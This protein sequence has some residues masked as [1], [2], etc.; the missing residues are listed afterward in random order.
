MIILQDKKNL[1]FF[2]LATIGRDMCGQLFS[3]AVLNYILFT[4]QLSVS[5]FSVVSF[6]IVAARL[7]DAFNDPFMGTLI[8]HTKTKIGKFKPWIIAGV[9]STSVV[10]YFAFSNRFIGW[11]FVKFFALIYFLFSI[12]FTMNDVSYWG[13]I[14]SL[15]SAPEMRDKFTSRTVFTSGMGAA[16]VTVFV[17]ILTAGEH[18][19]GGNAVTAYR[20]LAIIACVASPV[21]MMLLCFVKEN[22]GASSVSKNSISVS[23]IFR[24]VFRNDQLKWASVVFFVSQLGTV[25]IVNGL[26]TTYVYFEF[27]YNGILATL[28]V[29]VGMSSTVVMMLIYP[30]LAKKHSRKKL[31]ASSMYFMIFGYLWMLLSGIFLPYSSMIKYIFVVIGLAIANVGSYCVNLICM[32]CISNSIEYNE[33]KF[34]VREDG[35]ITSVRPFLTKLSNSFVML[36]TSVIYMLIGVTKITNLIS[37]VENRALSGAIDAAEKTDLIQTALSNVKNSQTFWLLFSMSVI[38][39][40]MGFACCMIFK[41][42]YTLDEDEYVR[43]VEELNRR[44]IE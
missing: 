16:F 27:G 12:C 19:I 35:V 14:P 17:P 1:I 44:K 30:A 2:P 42:K 5:Q 6:I 25:P 31:V 41:K 10:V 3:M 4:K 43:I 32:I 36:L 24:T 34:G 37:D 21:T 40:S 13:M 8:D 33:Y 11:G 18:V 28:F 26:G 15:S 23:G 9:L 29:V 38:A 20:V 39:L 22:R 7:F